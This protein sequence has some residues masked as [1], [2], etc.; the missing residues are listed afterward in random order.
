LHFYSTGQFFRTKKF[1][2]NRFS[3]FL[4]SRSILCLRERKI[5]SEKVENKTNRRRRAKND[6]Q[7]FIFVSRELKTT[8][9]YRDAVVKLVLEQGDQIGRMFAFLA[10]VYF[11][12]CLKY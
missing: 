3:T 9:R 8:E 7:F 6:A 12:Q 10:I 1:R 2:P 5:A 11:G 4:G